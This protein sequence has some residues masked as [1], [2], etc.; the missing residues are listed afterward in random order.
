MIFFDRSQAFATAVRLKIH[1]K[2]RKRP[3][4]ITRPIPYRHV[5]AQSSSKR[6]NFSTAILPILAV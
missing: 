2:G 1:F 3:N 6:Q 5:H 4:R